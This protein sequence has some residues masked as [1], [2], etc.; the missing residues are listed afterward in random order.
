MKMKMK[1]IGALG[2]NEDASNAAVRQCEG[3]VTAAVEMLQREEVVML[4]QFESAV[5]DMVSTVFVNDDFLCH[6]SFLL[7]MFPIESLIRNLYNL[8]A[9]QKLF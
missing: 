9:I 6:A 1:L 4:E 7:V 3:N 5:K 8:S 2:W